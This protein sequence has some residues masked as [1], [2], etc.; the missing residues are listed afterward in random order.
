MTIQPINLRPLK[1]GEILDRA[2]HLYRANFWLFI[3]IAGVLLVPLLVLELLSQFIFHDTRMID[4]IQSFLVGYLLHGA[5]IWASSRAYLGLPAL[6]NDSY[7]QAR[8]YFRPFFGAN[9]RMVL[10][11]FPIGIFAILILVFLRGGSG[12][13]GVVSTGVIILLVVPYVSFFSTRWG[14]SF[15]SIILEG[16]NGGEGL[17]RSWAL[18]SKDFWHVFWALVASGLLS[19]LV[20]VLPTLIIGYAIQQFQSF[21]EIGLML[22]SVLTQLGEIITIPLT[23]SI[24]VILYYDLRVRREGY[25]LEL[26]LEATDEEQTVSDKEDTPELE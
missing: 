17:K 15:P 26:A 6:M 10:A 16:L 2:F 8:R 22:S 5:M 19:Y 12:A 1:I 25:D 21:A 3:G 9:L 24:L 18:T 13:W 7:R 14:L 4:F 11:Y 23:V 20:T